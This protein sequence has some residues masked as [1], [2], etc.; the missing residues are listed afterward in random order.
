MERSSGRLSD[1]EIR[2]GANADSAQSSVGNCRR[3]SFLVDERNL[4]E[5]CAVRPVQVCAGSE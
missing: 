2:A 4:R 5:V 1:Y 3:E